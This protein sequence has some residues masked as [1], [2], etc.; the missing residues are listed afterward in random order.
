MP[1][2]TS[3]A[4]AAGAGGSVLDAAALAQFAEQGYVVVPNAV[5]AANLQAVVDL[6]WRFLGASGEDPESWYQVAP[7]ETVGGPAPISRAGMVEVYQQPELWNNR[8]YPRVY[9]AFADVWRTP[10]LWAT[11]DRANMKPPVRADRPEW[12]HGGF[13]HWDVDTAQDPI[14]F[15]VQGVL[16]LTDTAADQGGF[17]CVP[18]FP[19]RFAEWVR[20]QPADRD[21]RFP[22][23]TGLEVRSIPGRAGDL[24]IWNSLLPHGNGENTSQRPRLA[25]YISMFP[26]AR[27]DEAER[28]ERVAAW[29]EQ[30]AAG[31]WPG[32]PRGWERRHGRRAELTDLGRRLLGVD[33]WE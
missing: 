15:R 30:R 27:G 25:Q 3:G 16:Y 8:Q 2:E 21:P 31:G 29:R 10:H 33:A 23:L 11:L 19:R 24:L 6:I 12:Q 32:D 18:G 26:A 7:R 9:Q 4:P 14:P 1:Q 5:P 28:R 13:I 20:T 17:Q 22:D